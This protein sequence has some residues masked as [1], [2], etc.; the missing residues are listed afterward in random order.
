MEE[1]KEI[2]IRRRKLGLTQVQLAK[3]SGVSQSLIAK[4][5]RG[6]IDIAYSKAQKIFKAL[7]SVGRKEEKTVEEIMSKVVESVENGDKVSI[8]TGIMKRLQISQ[9]PV[10]KSG[11]CVGS[12]S[13]RDILDMMQKGLSPRKL[14]AMDVE[15]IMGET[16]PTLPK[17]ASL[18]E[19]AS[20]LQRNEAVLI[21]EKG[22][23]A[24]IVSKADLVKII[25]S[26]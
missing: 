14:A 12:V 26:K 15:E 23:V 20:L 7:E 1:L 2:G 22:K 4:L 16:F 24:G 11:L 25:S 21:I 3:L 9:V 8:A 13:E 6:I 5:E 19:V 17:S 18:N 10:L